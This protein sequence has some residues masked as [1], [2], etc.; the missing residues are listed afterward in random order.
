MNAGALEP[1]NRLAVSTASLIA[2]SGGIGS[3]PAIRSGYSSSSSATRRIER[4][5]GAI[6]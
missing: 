1:Q 3:S 5:T 2:A 6:R 4:S